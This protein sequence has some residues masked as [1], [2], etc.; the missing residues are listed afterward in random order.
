VMKMEVEVAVK[1]NV[2][3]CGFE[4]ATKQF[5]DSEI[6]KSP[7]NLSEEIINKMLSKIERMEEVGF[8]RETLRINWGGESL[9]NELNAPTAALFRSEERRVGKERRWRT[10]R[11][12]SEE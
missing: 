11:S 3:F 4:I 12:R 2:I 6:A 7:D 8:N 1:R 5:M 10:W 9:I